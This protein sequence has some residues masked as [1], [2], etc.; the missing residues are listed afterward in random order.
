MDNAIDLVQL[1]Q[2]FIA[3]PESDATRIV[4]FGV[5]VVLLAVVLWLLRR[6]KLREEYTPIW[7]GLSV[8][9]LVISVRLDFLRWITNAIGAWTTSS[10]V[11]FLGELFLLAICLSYAVRLSTAFLQLKNLSQEM[12]ILRTQVDTLRQ[13]LSASAASTDTSAGTR[14]DDTRGTAPEK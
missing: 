5:S 7:L 11:F 8:V 12:A 13:E 4:A 2:Q 9:L 6:G 3:S 10:T 1:R 14:P